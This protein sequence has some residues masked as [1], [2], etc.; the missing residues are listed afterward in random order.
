[1]TAQRQTY[2]PNGLNSMNKH[3]A[4]SRPLSCV[5]CEKVLPS[6]CP[7]CGRLV[8]VRISGL[9]Q[10]HKYLPIGQNRYVKCSFGR[11]GGS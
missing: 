7:Q 9:L 4:G 1:M 5:E 2:C 11:S 8:R 6:R 10:K 3:W